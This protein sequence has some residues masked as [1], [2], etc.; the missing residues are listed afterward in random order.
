MIQNVLSATSA[1]EKLSSLIKNVENSYERYVITVKGPPK[2]V[3]L[4]Y[5]EFEDLQEELEILS[6]NPKF[7]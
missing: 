6:Q 1:R 7:F 4:S 5:E 2:V 3:L